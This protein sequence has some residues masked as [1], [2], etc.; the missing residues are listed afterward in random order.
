MQALWD[1]ANEARQ[2]PGEY[3]DYLYG[4]H[5]AA[6][7]VEHLV[8]LHR[9]KLGV[10]ADLDRAMGEFGGIWHTAGET[11]SQIQ[12]RFYHSFGIDV[13]SA[14]ALSKAEAIKLTERI[15][16]TVKGA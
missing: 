2:T 5:L 16:N 4:K 9:E 7:K 8:K 11:D 10:H 14:Q 15:D 13:I 6:V 1:R 12:R 3:R